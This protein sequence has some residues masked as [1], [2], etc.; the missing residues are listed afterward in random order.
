MT[1][2]ADRDKKKRDSDPSP[3]KHPLRDEQD[4]HRKEYRESDKEAIDP[5]RKD[6]VKPR[7]D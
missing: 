4:P 6:E 2:R 3:K 5:H 1:V 7:D